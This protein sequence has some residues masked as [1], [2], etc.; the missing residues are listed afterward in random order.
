MTQV[1]RLSGAMLTRLLLLPC[2][3]LVPLI[4]VEWEQQ[5]AGA[6]EVAV[7][8][9][10]APVARPV[11]APPDPGYA[12]PAYDNYS[13]VLA[14]PPFSETRRPAP[15]GAV[16]RAIE[17]PLTATVVGTILAEGSV[18]ALVEHGEPP[19]VTRVLEGQDLDGWT[20]KTILQ[21]KIVLVRGP[22]TIELKVKGGTQASTTTPSDPTMPPAPPIPAASI[23][24]Q[25]LTKAGALP[26]PLAAPN[27]MVARRSPQP[28]AAP[29]LAATPA[30]AA[31]PS[32]AVPAQVVDSSNA[33]SP[34]TRGSSRS[35]LRRGR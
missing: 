24:T 7:T 28:A 19:Q 35:S 34:S 3:I 23:G 11:I 20:V 13:E 17:Q 32:E 30:V 16:A 4:Y 1:N 18:R 27:P 5:E 22:A 6:P 25:R 8:V 33:V 26:Q 9:A 21:E 12:M 15:P 31:A 10:D 2:L 14:R 29:T